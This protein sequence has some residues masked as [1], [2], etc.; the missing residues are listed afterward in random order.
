MYEF[1][2]ILMQSEAVTVAVSAIT[3]YA[4]LAGVVG[5]LIVGVAAFLKTKTQNPQICKALSDIQDIGK[6][7]T[8][9]S[10][11]TAEQQKDLQTVASVITTLSPEAKQLLEAHQKDA[12]YWKEKANVATQQLGVLLPLVPKEA[13]ANSMKDLPREN[14]KTLATIN[15]S[16]A[17]ATATTTKPAATT[18]TKTPA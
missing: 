16:E 11:K 5:A 2:T 8:A 12:E 17:M 3:S 13:Q 7:S 14:P 10:Q 4:A 6:L 15:A 1:G 9:F 18:T